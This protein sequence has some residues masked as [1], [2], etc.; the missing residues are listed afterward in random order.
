MRIAVGSDQA[1]Y[2]QRGHCRWTA[3]R[4]F[5]EVVGGVRDGLEVR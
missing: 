1:G 3:G 4:V 5:S 2:G